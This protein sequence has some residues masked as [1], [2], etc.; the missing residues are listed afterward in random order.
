LLPK[1]LARRAL[2]VDATLSAPGL[3]ILGDRIGLRCYG[4]AS[5]RDVEDRYL[6]GGRCL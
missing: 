5:C 3:P 4:T 1:L 2:V 6:V